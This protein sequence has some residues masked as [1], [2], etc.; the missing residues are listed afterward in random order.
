MGRKAKNDRSG[1]GDIK[2]VV[3]VFIDELLEEVRSELRDIL[4]ELE[5]YQRVWIVP[6]FVQKVLNDLC[7]RIGLLLD[8]L[9]RRL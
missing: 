7:I 9:G 2:E 1:D 8:K 4:R 6:Y 5:I 3:D